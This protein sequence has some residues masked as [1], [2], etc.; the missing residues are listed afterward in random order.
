MRQ[1]YDHV[2]ETA[3]TLCLTI[4]ATRGAKSASLFDIRVH[5]EANEIR[6]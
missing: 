1:S 2:T 5:H 3:T 6:Q 4:S